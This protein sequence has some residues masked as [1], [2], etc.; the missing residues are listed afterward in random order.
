MN[1]TI[2]MISRIRHVT[3]KSDKCPRTAENVW[4]RLLIIWRVWDYLARREAMNCAR[5]FDFVEFQ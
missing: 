4:S 3:G 1:E 2:T 5:P